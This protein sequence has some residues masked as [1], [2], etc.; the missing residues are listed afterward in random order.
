MSIKELQNEIAKLQNNVNTV[1]N[2]DKL[3]EQ[4]LDNKYN[5]KTKKLKNKTKFR[6]VL[7]QAGFSKI[8]VFGD[9]NWYEVGSAYIGEHGEEQPVRIIKY[10]GYMTHQEITNLIDDLESELNKE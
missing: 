1:E 3:L 4:I 7:Y 2:V 9:G 5:V 8:A 10:R 6:T